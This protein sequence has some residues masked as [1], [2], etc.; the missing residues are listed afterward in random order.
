MTDFAERRRVMVDTQIRPSDVTKF[1]VIDAMLSVPR[2]N[3]VPD[4]MRAVAYAEEMIELEPGRVIVEPRTLGKMLDMLD[5]QPTESMLLVGGGLG[6]S[7]AVA[8]HLA[9][10]VVAVEDDE[11][12]AQDTLTALSDAGADNAIVHDAA[13]TE[14][15]A[16]HGPYDLILIEGGVEEVPAALLDQ[17]KD[18]GRIA[19]IFMAGALGEV[20]LGH[21]ADGR[22]TWRFAFN[23]TAPVL[24]GFFKAKTFSL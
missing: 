11:T 1:P 10:L 18:G 12:R 8:A 7:A 20:R 21:K 13:L 14:G 15:A 19:S 16:E 17:L 23:A 5:I 4:V 3:F 24:P 9:Q 2:E 6:Y 22:I